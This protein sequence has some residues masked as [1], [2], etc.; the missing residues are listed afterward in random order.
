M[1]LAPRLYKCQNGCRY[2][3]IA[4]CCWFNTFPLRKDLIIYSGDLARKPYYQVSHCPYCNTRS[5]LG[6]LPRI[7]C[8]FLARC[9]GCFRL[10]SK[11][12]VFAF[13]SSRIMTIMAKRARYH[14]VAGAVDL[15]TVAKHFTRRF[16][17]YLSR[18]IRISFENSSRTHKKLVSQLYAWT[19][20]KYVPNSETVWSRRKYT[21]FQKTLMKIQC[22]PIGAPYL[23]SY[24]KGFY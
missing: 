4:A 2:I 14:N 1:R 24:I 10:I 16:D 11:R 6:Q 8:R 13:S 5:L 7:S 9:G 3:H 20:T 18:T 12:C 17:N 15:M 23:N 21:L 22:V 19:F